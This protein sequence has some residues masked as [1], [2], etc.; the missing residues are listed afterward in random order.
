[1]HSILLLKELISLK[2]RVQFDFVTY[3]FMGLICSVSKVQSDSTSALPTFDSLQSGVNF[4]LFPSSKISKTRDRVLPH[5]QTLGR[6]LKIRRTAQC[7]VELRRVW[8]LW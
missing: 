2:K 1:M 3:N 8:K 4:I 6:E 5:S 7:F